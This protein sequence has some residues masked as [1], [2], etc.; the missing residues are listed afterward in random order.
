MASKSEIKVAEQILDRFFRDAEGKTNRQIDVY[1]TLEDMD[2]PRDKADPALQFLTSRGLINQFGPD[3]A[4]LTDHGIHAMVEELDISKLEKVLKDFIQKPVEQAPAP[5]PAQPQQ[6]PA[7]TATGK[8][9]SP[10]PE[11]PSLTHIDLE[12][13]EYTLPLGQLCTIGRSD[14]N[15]VRVNDQRASKMHA[16]IRFE[17]GAFVLHDLESANGTLLNGQYVID[18]ETLKHDDEVVIGRTM[19]LFTSP[20][21][22]VAPVPADAPDE[23]EDALAQT[24][25]GGPTERPGPGE[26]DPAPIRV[27]KG[28]PAPAPTPAPTPAAASDLFAEPARNE[29]ASDLFSQPPANEGGGLFGD[30]AP[31]QA[32]DDLFGE[33][34]A[35][36]APD[37]DL[38]AETG[39]L[40]RQEAPARAPRTETRED[41]F[42][43]SQ[44]IAASPSGGDL[45]SDPEPS[46][47]PPGDLFGDD[48]PTSAADDLFDGEA[49][50][51]ST[52]R[53]PVEAPPE[54]EV[55]PLAPEAPA[56]VEPEPEP[57]PMELPDDAL[58]ELEPMDTVA[59]VPVVEETVDATVDA[60]WNEP[61][62]QSAPPP[63]ADDLLENQPVVKP[64]GNPDD[65]NT[66]MM[67]R[68]AL[69]DAAGVIPGPPEPAVEP[70]PQEEE[71]PRWGD[72]DAPMGSHPDF[73]AEAARAPKLEGES[74]P[75]A[76]PQMAEI[77]PEGAPSQPAQE[78]YPFF[79]ALA[80]LRNDVERADLDDK[81]EL[82]EAIERL[83]GHPYVRVAIEKQSR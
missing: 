48:A 5:A 58:E 30:E 50:I 21:V 72:A 71:E 29:S 41:L 52:S 44:D 42:A 14:G 47:A 31:T 16:E 18:P 45:F 55:V 81:R 68:D 32:K 65:A 46:T 19:L 37:G 49:T 4:F 70:A 54:L 56:V 77:A 38:F 40:P 1:F 69:F 60:D 51:A 6:Q 8:A 13:Q 64:S 66:V 12:G 15:Q 43:D 78:E 39:E 59:S 75:I 25:V 34:E 76:T 26:E 63:S 22:I 82:L 67:T 20:E 7:P 80:E 17:N 53:Q 35:R 83:Y 27:V 36:P 11:V 79:A 28:T 74:L 2:I 9:A 24:I 3:I 61:T 73:A 62:P 23:E 57:E 10:R 33:P